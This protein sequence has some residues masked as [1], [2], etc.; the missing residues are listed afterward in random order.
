M[1]IIE[2]YN[3]IKLRYMDIAKLNRKLEK[4]NRKMGILSCQ[5]REI[6]NQLEELERDE[7]RY[8]GTREQL[9]E[10]HN[11]PQWMV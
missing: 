1:A 2:N 11:L 9:K 6:K 3:R 4:K 10:K 8:E 7:W 5:I